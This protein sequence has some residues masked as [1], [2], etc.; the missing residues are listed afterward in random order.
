MKLKLVEMLKSHFVNYIL[1]LMPNL[2]SAF[3]RNFSRLIFNRISISGLVRPKLDEIEFKMYS[4]WDDGAVD[5]L[6]FN[7]GQNWS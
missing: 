4:K 5:G 6:Y 7:D 1:R 2:W 3:D